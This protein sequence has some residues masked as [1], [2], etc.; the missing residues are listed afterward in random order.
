MGDCRDMGDKTYCGGP[1]LFKKNLEFQGLKWGEMCARMINEYQN[2]EIIQAVGPVMN[3][4]WK[5]GKRINGVKLKELLTKKND[6]KEENGTAL[7]TLETAA[8][9]AVSE[10]AKMQEAEEE[11]KQ[12]KQEKKSFRPGDLFHKKAKPEAERV[13]E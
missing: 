3:T 11:E 1:S 9:E 8:S 10:T 13:E 2:V 6:K 12:E 5:P 4:A 7:Q